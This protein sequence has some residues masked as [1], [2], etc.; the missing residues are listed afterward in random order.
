MEASKK[1]GRTKEANVNNPQQSEMAI[2]GAPRDIM[3]EHMAEI[4]SCSNHLLNGVY[5]N[6]ELWPCEAL[7]AVGGE[8]PYPQG[9]LHSRAQTYLHVPST[10]SASGEHRVSF[11]VHSVPRPVM[12]DTR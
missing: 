2:K 5:V 3:D 4:M 10:R 9:I 6:V 7:T 12:G 1:L 8:T 11:E